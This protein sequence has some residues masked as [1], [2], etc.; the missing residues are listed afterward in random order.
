MTQWKDKRAYGKMLPQLQSLTNVNGW[1]LLLTCTF[2][3]FHALS[4]QIKADNEFTALSLGWG[5]GVRWGGGGGRGGGAE[6]EGQEGKA[7]RGH[8]GAPGTLVFAEQPWEPRRDQEGHWLHPTGPA[9]A[10]QGPGSLRGW[11]GHSLCAPALTGDN[12]NPLWLHLRNPDNKAKILAP[13][14]VT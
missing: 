6:K 4:I 8:R 7:R 3:P 14:P 9:L 11:M 5:G 2:M 13:A 1:L 12:W 10:P